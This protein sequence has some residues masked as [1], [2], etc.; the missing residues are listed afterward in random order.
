MIIIFIFHPLI[1]FV[2]NFLFHL[3]LSLCIVLDQLILLQPF[4]LFFNLPFVF[5]FF[6]AL[7]Q[8]V[9]IIF[10]NLSGNAAKE[11]DEDDEKQDTET[12]VDIHIVGLWVMVHSILLSFE[13]F[14]FFKF[15]LFCSAVSFNDFV[16]VF[17]SLFLLGI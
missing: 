2:S 5:L 1:Q 13:F 8:V 3:L 7:H 6:F 4:L 11:V 17:L 9:R 12:D 16:N 15:A 10:G 14:F